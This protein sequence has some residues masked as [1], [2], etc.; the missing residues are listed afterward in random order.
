MPEKL[1]QL[2]SSEATG[3]TA[4]EAINYLL[5]LNLWTAIE[6]HGQ[7]LSGSGR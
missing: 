5:T 6:N 3:I 2:P 1:S 7:D 4:V